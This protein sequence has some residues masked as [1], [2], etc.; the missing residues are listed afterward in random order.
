[1]A[2]FHTKTATLVAVVPMRSRAETRWCGDRE[3]EISL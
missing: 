1:M 3:T 2:E